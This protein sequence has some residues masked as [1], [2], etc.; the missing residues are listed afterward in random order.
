[1]NKK[2]NSCVY[3]GQ[4]YAEDFDKIDVVIKFSIRTPVEFNNFEID[5]HGGIHVRQSRCEICISLDK[6]ISKKLF[7]HISLLSQ[8]DVKS[9]SNEELQKYAH[10]TPFVIGYIRKVLPLIN[11]EIIKRKYQEGLILART[12]SITDVSDIFILDITKPINDGVFVIWPNPLPGFPSSVEISSYADAI[13][14]RDLIES[15]TAFF[16]FNFDDCIR[17][18]ITSLENCLL[19]YYKLSCKTKK[20]FFKNCFKREKL[21]KVVN[22]YIVEK[23][24]INKGYNEKNLKIIRQNIKYIYHIRNQ[25][26]HNQLRANLELYSIYKKAIGTLLYVYQGDFIDKNEQAYV[27]SF[28]LQFLAIDDGGYSGL[29]IINFK[30]DVVEDK[31]IIKNDKDLNERMFKNLEITKNEVREF[32]L[33]SKV[34]LKAERKPIPDEILRNLGE[35][36]SLVPTIRKK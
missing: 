36:M 7:D 20:H 6:T 29:P 34:K 25:I 17:K 24:Y 23:N 11:K 35:P 19:I 22:E 1:M 15:M 14:I 10:A 8:K 28:Y 2:D 26:V 13:Y 32:E 31:K 30:D 16:D 4:E 9:L 12:A 18:V 27:F 33:K 5:L 3:V 21:I